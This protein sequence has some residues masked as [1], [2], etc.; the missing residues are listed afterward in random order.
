MIDSSVVWHNLTE[1][2]ENVAFAWKL[3]RVEKIQ[4]QQQLE[5]AVVIVIKA[6]ASFFPVFETR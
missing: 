3:K 5:Q 6:N 2:I 1:T 4:G